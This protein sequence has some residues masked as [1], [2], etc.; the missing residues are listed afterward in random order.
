MRRST[1]RR[2]GIA[3]GSG[4]PERGQHLRREDAGA[5]DARR[6][7]ARAGRARYEGDL[8]G[9]AYEESSH[10][11]EPEELHHR[12]RRDRRAGWC[13]LFI[14][15]L[16]QEHTT[17]RPV[18]TTFRPVQTGP[19]SPFSTQGSPVGMGTVYLALR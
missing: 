9:I 3:D 17:F 7:R 8:G 13:V 18:R 16:G 2:P 15:A 6:D 12:G 10:D 19:G 1:W 5:S 4:R 11:E 14:G